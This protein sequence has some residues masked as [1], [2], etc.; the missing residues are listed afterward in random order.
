MSLCVRLTKLESEHLVEWPNWLE[1]IEGVYF[2]VKTGEEARTFREYS[3]GANDVQVFVRK[4]P[5]TGS[6]A[7]IFVVQSSLKSKPLVSYSFNFNGALDDANSFAR[8]QALSLMK[9]YSY[10]GFIDE[11]IVT[12]P[13]F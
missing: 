4:Q 3:P 6:H 7:P 9:N 10:A 2:L 1:R 12:P 8:T 11:T 5:I 13:S